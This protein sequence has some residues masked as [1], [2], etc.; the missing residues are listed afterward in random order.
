[1]IHFKEQKR[2]SLRRMSRH[3]NAGVRRPRLML[4]TSARDK[5]FHGRRGCSLGTAAL[6]V[7]LG[8]VEAMSGCLTTLLCRSAVAAL[9]VLGS[10][11]E[12]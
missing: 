12:C 7:P 4:M 1:M 8:L 2:Y 10:S 11:V 3:G 5:V 6:L 9:G